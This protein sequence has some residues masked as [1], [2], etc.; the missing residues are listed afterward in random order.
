MIYVEKIKLPKSP[1][2][3][4]Y[5]RQKTK[6]ANDWC[7]HLSTRTE[8]VR[9]AIIDDKNDECYDVEAEICVKCNKVVKY[10]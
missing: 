8:L 10:L 9:N 2:D 5:R 6:V 7:K 1:I 4:E 3:Q